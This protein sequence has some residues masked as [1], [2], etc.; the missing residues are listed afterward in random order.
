M[1]SRRVRSGTLVASK[2]LEFY[3]SIGEGGKVECT[4]FW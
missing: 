1:E 2:D 4:S 3:G